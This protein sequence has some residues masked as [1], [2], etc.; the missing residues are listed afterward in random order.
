VSKSAR[1]FYGALA[2]GAGV[3]L[4]VSAI[5]QRDYPR[6]VLPLVV[7]ALAASRRLLKNRTA[8]QLLPAIILA[9]AYGG[10]ALLALVMSVHELLTPRPYHG[11][12]AVA[13]LAGG[14][15]MG[16]LTV[17]ITM[18]VLRMRKAT[19]PAVPPTS[20]NPSDGNILPTL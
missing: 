2:I 8:S 19:A 3:W 10:T 4:T 6:L 20:P 12:V 14:A 17:L 13:E 18:G 11:E 9:G 16:G 5:Q 7:L 1:M 15:V